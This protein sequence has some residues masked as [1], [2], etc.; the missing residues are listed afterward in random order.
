MS[1]SMTVPQ[2]LDEDVLGA[3]ASYDV[4]YEEDGARRRARHTR[5]GPVVTV[6]TGTRTPTRVVV[7]E[8]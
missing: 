4:A 7:S 6:T 2:V 1:L 3:A 8:L 5:G